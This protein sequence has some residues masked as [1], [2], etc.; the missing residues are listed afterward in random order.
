[1]DI[2]EPD[3]IEK[4]EKLGFIAGIITA[5]FS[6]F[7]GLFVVLGVAYIAGAIVPAM[8]ESLEDKTALQLNQQFGQNQQ[9]VTLTLP[10]T[11]APECKIEMDD[12]VINANGINGFFWFNVKKND[13][14]AVGPAI[15]RWMIKVL[16]RYQCHFQMDTIIRR[17][18]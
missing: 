1:V 14:I 8:I 12:F 4:L 6:P 5:A 17:I 9:G 18:H 2:K 3:L 15:G 13:Y 7:L 16:Y 11:E 10:G